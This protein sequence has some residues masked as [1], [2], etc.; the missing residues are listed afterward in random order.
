MLEKAA[1]LPNYPSFFA[2]ALLGNP[3]L[4]SAAFGQVQSRGLKAEFSLVKNE[5][6][7]KETVW[8]GKWSCASKFPFLAL[9][10][11]LQGAIY[12]HS[13]IV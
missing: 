12:L 9:Q 13:W 11:H 5:T 10:K 7:L 6:S 1:Y 2:E 4:M 3:T 8:F